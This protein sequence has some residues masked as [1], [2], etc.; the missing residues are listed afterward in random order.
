[1]QTYVTAPVRSAAVPSTLEPD[2]TH[3]EQQLF[4]SMQVWV[5]RSAGQLVWDVPPGLELRVTFQCAEE[6]KNFVQSM[7]PQFQ[8]YVQAVGTLFTKVQARQLAGQSEVEKIL[9]R[10]IAV[11]TPASQSVMEL[12][13]D[14]DPPRWDTN[15]VLIPKRALNADL[16]TIHPK[17]FFECSVQVHCRL[18]IKQDPAEEIQL[19][20]ANCI[21]EWT[22]HLA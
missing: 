11:E 20:S 13:P 6:Y 16:L 4:G 7:L 18:L 9:H 8:G 14:S 1:M 2:Q 12:V 10:E 5:S 21:P 22:Y 17:A 15:I 19:G 3:V